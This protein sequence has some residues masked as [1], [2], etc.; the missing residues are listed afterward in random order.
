M[1]RIETTPSLNPTNPGS[2][3]VERRLGVSVLLL[4][5]LWLTKAFAAVQFYAVTPRAG[6]LL[7][8][9]LTWITAAAAL[10]TGTW[11]INPDADTGGREPLLPM[12]HPKWTTK[13]RWE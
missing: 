4:Y 6:V 11:W 13:F 1:L 7:A 2:N 8:V 5:G 10:Q 12:V 3:N 9:T